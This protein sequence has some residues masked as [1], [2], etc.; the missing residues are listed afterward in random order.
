MKNQSLFN[1][2]SEHHEEAYC[3]LLD[4][5]REL[6]RTRGRNNIYVPYNVQSTIRT[7]EFEEL[8]IEVDIDS[9]EIDECNCVIV[10]YSYNGNHYKDPA[11]LFSYDELYGILS[12]VCS[13]LEL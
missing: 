6:V 9:L 8:E 12:N 1:K 3:Y 2:L 5:A 11:S 7:E 13:C 4:F 10:R